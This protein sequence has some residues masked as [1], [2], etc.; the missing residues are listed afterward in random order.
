MFWIVYYTIWTNF[1]VEIDI[2]PDFMLIYTNQYEYLLT[3]HLERMTIALAQLWIVTFIITMDHY[4]SI[5][6]FLNYVK[7]FRQ[8]PRLQH[9]SDKMAPK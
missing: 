5:F 8:I 4:I 9:E 1:V 6:L 7:K 2:W 3:V